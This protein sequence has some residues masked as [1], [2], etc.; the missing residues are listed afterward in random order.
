MLGEPLECLGYADRRRA[1]CC[2]LA[3]LMRE[4]PA[5]TSA[6]GKDSTRCREFR[7][8]TPFSPRLSATG[9]G[10]V[11]HAV[12]PVAPHGGLRRHRAW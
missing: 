12:I 2:R 5:V 3:R 1:N 7:L 11:F 4:F 10:C 8:S 6:V 9:V